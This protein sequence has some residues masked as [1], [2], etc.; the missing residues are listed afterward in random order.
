MVTSPALLRPV[1]L[2]GAFSFELPLRYSTTA[3]SV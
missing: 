1:I 2:I 3:S